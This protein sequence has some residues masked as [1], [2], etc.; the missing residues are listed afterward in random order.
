MKK[1]FAGG[2]LLF[3]FAASVSAL[4]AEPRRDIMGINIGMSK[5]AARHQLQKLGQLQREERKRQ[6]VWEL[7]DRHFSHL[8]VGFD[9]ASQVRFVTAVARE[10]G[11]RTLYSDVAELKKA[12]QI[13]DVAINNFHYVWELAAGGQVPKTIVVAR[14]RNPKY[15]TTYSIKR[16]D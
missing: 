10:D 11:E 6:E 12:R 16:A 15:L 1:L 8:I 3:L 4:V 5:E 7:R 14:G 9:K 13:G 2:L